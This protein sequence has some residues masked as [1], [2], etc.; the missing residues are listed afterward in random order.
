MA[1]DKG[2]KPSQGHLH[3]RCADVGDPNCRWEARGHDDAEIIQQ[4]EQH[5]REIHGTQSLDND[6][7]NRIRGVL[8][9]RKA[10]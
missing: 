4:V 5:A 7:R 1:H 8:H 10:A 9:G 2:K 6:A 3:I